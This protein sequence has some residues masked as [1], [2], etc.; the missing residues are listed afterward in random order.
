MELTRELIIEKINKN[1]TNFFYGL[2]NG[3]F[4]GKYD[5][6]VVTKEV[7][8]VY[9][10]NYG[11]GNEWEIAFE[12]LNLNMFALLEGSYSSWDSPEWDSV[13]H[14]EPFKFTET[15]F[16]KATLAYIR[17]QKIDEVLKKD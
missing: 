6:K 17:D 4:D 16:K 9:D 14:A 1:D 11:D 5:R 2:Y 7:K 12:F 13:S 8:V 15:R 3:E 10:Q